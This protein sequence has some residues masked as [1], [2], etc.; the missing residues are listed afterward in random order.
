MWLQGLQTLLGDREYWESALPARV[1]IVWQN[2]DDLFGLD[3]YPD[4]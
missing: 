1:D 3:T 4:P 2:L